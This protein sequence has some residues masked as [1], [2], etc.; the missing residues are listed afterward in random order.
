MQPE[1]S[2]LIVDDSSAIRQTVKSTLISM[3]YTNIQIAMN[4]KDA[5]EKIRSHNFKVIFLDWNMP[6]M[7]GLTFLKV[8]RHELG[9]KDA[10]VIMLTAVS[11]KKD[12][13]TAMENGATA[14]VTKPVSVE[15]IKKKMQQAVDWLATHTH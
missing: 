8:F 9:I 11:D 12:V 2:I 3:G 13:L 7:D 10:A 15:T 6:E 5:L 4:G 1:I 14:Y